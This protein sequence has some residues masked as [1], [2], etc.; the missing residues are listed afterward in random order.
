M[1]AMAETLFAPAHRESF[2]AYRRAMAIAL[3]WWSRTVEHKEP[4]KTVLWDMQKKWKLGRT[5]IVAARR[6]GA[7]R[8]RAIF[9]RSENLSKTSIDAYVAMMTRQV[10]RGP[11]RRRRLSLAQANRLIGMTLA[12]PRNLSR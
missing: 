3:E 8:L 6:T 1:L 5:Q 10:V 11:L 12:P 4:P 9:E 7:E 2:R